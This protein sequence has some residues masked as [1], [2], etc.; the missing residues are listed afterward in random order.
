MKYLRA[1]LHNHSTQSDGA[2]TVEQLAAYAAGKDFG[3]LALTDHNT[4]AGQ[5]AAA[6][7]IR[8]NGYDLGLL[9]GIEVTTFY[10]H[11]LA[12]G[13]GQM[14][15]LTLLDP[16]APEAFFRK[17]RQAGARAVGIAHP[18][19][20]GEPL[21]VGCR[22]GLTLRDWGAVDYI[23]VANTAMSES[24][25]GAHPLAERFS[26]NGQALALWES[27]VLAGHRLAAVSGKDLHAAPVEAEVFTTYALVDDGCALP[28]TEAVLAAI[29]TQRTLVT[30]GPLFDIQVR[31]GGLVVTFAQHCP[32]LGWGV[33]RAG[34]SLTLEVRDS[35]GHVQHAALRRE[36]PLVL[37][38]PPGAAS[39]VVKLYDGPCDYEHLAAVGAPVYLPKE[40]TP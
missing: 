32:Y 8:Q 39:A 29:L 9:P 24:P 18:Y 20:I 7:A 2:L 22:F 35:T 14:V 40:A 16:N 38:L 17:L 5:A 15:D 13:L 30:K 27:L 25:L 19:C 36:T 6:E 28:R 26:G 3:V 11:I 37:P 34:R 31:D 1:E 21:M 4:A 33:R 10:G 12:L 23:E